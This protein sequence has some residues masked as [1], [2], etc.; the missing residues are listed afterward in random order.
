MK[1]FKE[2]RMIR[3]IT[4]MVSLFFLAVGLLAATQHVM[5]LAEKAKVK[6]D[7]DA[8]AAT[9]YIAAKGEVFTVLERRGNWYK[10]EL[11]T[12]EG[13][14]PQAGFIAKSL[15]S[16]SG[17]QGEKKPVRKGSANR[18]L[19]PD[20]H[21]FSGLSLKL[22]FKTSPKGDSFGN[23]WI[24]AGTYEKKLGRY[25]SLGAELQPYL[26]HYANDSLPGTSLSIFAVHTFVNVKAGANLGQFVPVLKFWKPYFGL[27][28]G[29]A[30]ENQTAKYE[31]NSGSA[32][33]IYFA[34]HWMLGSEFAMKKFDLIVEF[35]SILLGVPGVSPDFFTNFIMFGVRF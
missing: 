9:I 22:G 20:K 1:Y 28:F 2:K 19:K 35:Q 13:A 15:V 17:G 8:G 34:W 32:F 26:R 5:V 16:E 33:E 3:K 24:L 18:S 29:A 6:A 14:G 30:F 7:A 31:G 21:L 12:E 4:M 27:G 23:S 25:L 10:I 11:P